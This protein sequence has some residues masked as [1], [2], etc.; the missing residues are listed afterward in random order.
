MPEKALQPAVVLVDGSSYLYRAFHAL[1]PLATSDG[2]PTGALK[3]VTAMVRRL[4]K[5]Y[6]PRYL[7][8]IMDAP[9]KNF[10]HDLYAE[11]KATRP[12]MPEELR[13]Q[14]EPLKGIIEAMGIPLLVIEGV[15][16]DDVIG[17]LAAEAES[18]GL[19]TLISTGDKD[20]AQLVSAHVTLVNT[21]N[22]EVLDVAGVEAKFGVAPERIIDYLALVGDKSDN[23]PGVPKVGP[24]TAVKW[25]QQ[26]GSLDAIMESAADIG[27]KIGENLRGAL[28]TLPLSRDLVTI[29][30]ELD[31]PLRVK[32][33]E[34]AAED[35]DRLHQVFTDL[36]FR[37]WAEEYA[38]A[39]GDAQQ[40]AAG[41][42]QLEV[43]TVLDKAGLEKWVRA[44]RKAGRFS[45][46][47]ET[48]SLN[49]MQARLVGVSFAVEPGRAAYVPFGH[50]YEGAP[51]QLSAEV[52]LDA[53]RS[54]LEDADLGK[55]GQNLKYDM[56]VL[57]GA[58]ITLRG[59]R[60]DCMLASY[61]LDS[62]A[63]HDMDSLAER[64][65]GQRTIHFEDVAGK[66]A[67]QITFNQV[68]VEQAAPYAAEDADVALRL[69]RDLLAELE[70]TPALHGI[71]AELEIPLVP[72][73]SRMER[74]G[75]ALDCDA[76]ARQSDEIRSSLEELESEAFAM[77]GVEFNVASTQQLQDVLYNR[78]GLPVL[79]KTPGGKPSTNEAT[80]LELAV[81]YELPRVILEHRTLSKLKNTYT[82]RLPEQV[83]PDTGRLHTSYHQAVT[84]TGRLSSTDPN[85]QNI[86]I[87]RPEG[88]RVRRAFVARD[89]YRILSADYS[90]IELRIMAHMSGDEG[91]L[92][93]FAEGRDIHRATASEVFGVPEAEVSAE[94][95][96]AA[97]AINFGLIYGMS[98][99]GLARQLQ[100]PRHEAQ[101]YI[102]RYFERYPGVRRYMDETRESGRERGYVET[103]YGRR[104]YL[105]EIRARN[106]NRRQAAER[107][108]INAPMQGTAADIIKRAMIDIDAWLEDRGPDAAMIMQ[109]H[110][111]LVFEVREDLVEDVAAEVAARMAAAGELRSPLVVDCG[112]GMNWEEA[113]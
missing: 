28:D 54:L 41:A 8:V 79:R 94:D 29:R 95:R 74:R 101:G 72:V 96:R 1:P 73:L 13:D 93:A 109:V 82:D 24:K 3:G 27:G 50:D 35:R 37:A 56:N 16:A 44:L 86:P 90:Q 76:L 63:R 18:Q 106:G 80:L 38:A 113:H 48:T 32:E 11:Y 34:P 45:F 92:Q 102:D 23:V 22:D 52:V 39:P 60:D 4:C 55:I 103:L 7:A 100:L 17:T 97:K 33:L 83:D 77:A 53:L 14:V 88:R 43:D 59:I 98:A 9:G 65:L 26:Y 30:R 69:Q 36:E 12:S 75:A 49:Y 108:A 91:L 31:L 105:P 84:A 15:E 67:K 111:E 99:F 110:D 6:Q 58:G 78:L 85:L 71:Y 70:K 112:S 21:M 66:G 104:L 64:R 61:V 51:E 46:D 47:T 42:G 5:D 40:P 89:G 10:R 25:L 68:P 107:T 19:E 2:R 62:T 87:R 20:L 81:D 57:A